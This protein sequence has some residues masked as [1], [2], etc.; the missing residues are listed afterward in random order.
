MTRRGYFWKL[1][2]RSFHGTLRVLETG[3]ALVAITVYTVSYF[4]HGWREPLEVLFVVLVGLLVLTFFFGMF[5]AAYASNQ[6]MEAVV[7]SHQRTIAELENQ[8]NPR[9]V[10]TERRRLAE[11]EVA[12]L[13]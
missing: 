4:H 6:E 13:S 1:V 11:Q 12:R 8:P 7:L 10:H 9:G 5:L 3:E 2:R